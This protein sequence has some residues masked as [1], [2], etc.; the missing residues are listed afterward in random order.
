MG[1]NSEVQD[2]ADQAAGKEKSTRRRTKAH[3]PWLTWAEKKAKEWGSP[4]CAATRAHTTRSLMLGVILAA[5][6]CRQRRSPR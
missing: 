2:Q 6:T 3:C 4:S 5:T 1:R